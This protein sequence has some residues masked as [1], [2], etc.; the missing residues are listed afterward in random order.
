M[1]KVSLLLLSFLEFVS[2]SVDDA[3]FLA[4][5][6][7]ALAHDLIELSIVHIVTSLLH[8]LFECLNSLKV[9]TLLLMLLLHLVI[10]DGLVELLV[11]GSVLLLFEALHLGLLL[12]D[13]TLY[14]IHVSI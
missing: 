3:L 1:L 14:S 12:E 5:T 8:L 2:D 11:L 4:R 13:A 7:L 6:L 9:L 10:L